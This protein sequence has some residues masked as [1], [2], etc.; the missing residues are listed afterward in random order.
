MSQ[1]TSHNVPRYILHVQAHSEL[2]T[3][4]VELDR[5]CHI[6]SAESCPT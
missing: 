4:L 5:N 2:L 1:S 6:H 3:Q